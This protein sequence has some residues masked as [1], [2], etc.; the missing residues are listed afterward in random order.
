LAESTYFSRDSA[1]IG[2]GWEFLAADVFVED[3]LE[4]RHFRRAS[5]AGTSSRVSR[6]RAACIAIAGAGISIVRV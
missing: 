6:R 1:E 4:H 2:V 3:S 5:S